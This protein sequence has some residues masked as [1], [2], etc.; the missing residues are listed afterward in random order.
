M[1]DFVS[2]SYVLGVDGL[3]V[4]QYLFYMDGDITDGRDMD[5]YGYAHTITQWVMEL[6]LWRQ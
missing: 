2:F 3:F 5:R 1:I 6:V 4:C